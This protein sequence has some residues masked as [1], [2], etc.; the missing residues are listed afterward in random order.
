MKG[1]LKGGSEFT[2]DRIENVASGYDVE[3][4]GSAGDLQ[5]RGFVPKPAPPAGRPPANPLQAIHKNDEITSENAKPQR[6]GRIG[7]GRG[8]S[9]VEQRRPA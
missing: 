6:T 5:D 1:I 2:M 3:S 7:E 9:L 4:L 8:E